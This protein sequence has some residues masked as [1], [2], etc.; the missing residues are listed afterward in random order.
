MTPLNNATA[1][2]QATHLQ[3]ESTAQ[4]IPDN[5]TGSFKLYRHV[6]NFGDYML[7]FGSLLTA[8]YRSV[9]RKISDN[10]ERPISERLV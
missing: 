3:A 1:Q 4:P 9:I 2:S 7:Q 10:D 5:M 8:G 6:M